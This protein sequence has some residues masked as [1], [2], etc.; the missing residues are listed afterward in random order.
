M[1]DRG[2]FHPQM[3]QISADENNS[4]PICVH[5]RHLRIAVAFS[6]PQMKTTASLSASICAICG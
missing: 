5:L 6:L 1:K 2:S 3:T 4:I